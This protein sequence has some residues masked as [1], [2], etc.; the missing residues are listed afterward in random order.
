MKRSLVL[1]VLLTL[2]ACR[3]QDGL[4]PV[5]RTHPRAAQARDD[6]VNFKFTQASYADAI[7]RAGPGVVTIR[8]ARRQR[9]AQQPFLADPLSAAFNPTQAGN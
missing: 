7:E 2:V 4:E 3:E 1:A 6:Q 8:A 9:A 5:S